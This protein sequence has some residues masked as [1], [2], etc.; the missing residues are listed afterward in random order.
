MKEFLF[1][2]AFVAIF[3]ALALDFGDVTVSRFVLNSS[4]EVKHEA[5]AAIHSLGW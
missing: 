4:A 3:T 2:L 5:S 1:A